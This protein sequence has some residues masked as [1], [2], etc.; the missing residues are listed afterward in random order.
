MC[1]RRLPF[2]ADLPY[3]R[4][5]SSYCFL[6]SAASTVICAASASGVS[7]TYSSLTSSG[8]WNALPLAS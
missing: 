5:L 3:W 2:F 7:I 8:T 1:E 6:T 4:K